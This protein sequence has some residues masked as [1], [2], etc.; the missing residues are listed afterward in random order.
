LCVLAA[1]VYPWRH[2]S[3]AR[4]IDKNLVRLAARNDL[5]ISGHNQDLRFASGLRHGRHNLCQRIKRKPLFQDET[6]GQIER[7][8]PAHG[9]I[10]DGAMDGEAAYVAAREEDGINHVGIGGDGNL[11]VLHLYQGTVVHLSE[12][13]ILKHVDEKVLHELVRRSAS[14]SLVKLNRS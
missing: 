8:G 4:R 1:Y 9:K 11:P 5:R 7:P 6:G 3:N 14:A 10:V 12:V 13:F 2:N